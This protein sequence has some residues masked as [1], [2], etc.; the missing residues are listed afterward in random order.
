MAET[1]TAGRLLAL[2]SLLQGR[3]EWPGTLLARRLEVSPRTVRRDVERLRALGYPIDSTSGPA[4]GYSLTAGAAMPP[5]L[6]DDEEAIAVAIALRTAARSAVAGIEETALRAMVKLEQVLPGHL[7]RRVQALG[8]ATE[9]V[10][11]GGGPTVDGAVLT[12]LGTACRDQELLRFGYRGRDG[13]SS[14]RLVE[15]HALLARG[16]RWYLLAFD[17]SRAAWR[18]FRVDRVEA[19]SPA[20][21]GFRPRSIP[22]GDAAGYLTRT[23]A[24]VVYRYEARIRY[25]ASAAELRGRPAG[26]WGNLRDAADGCCICETSD[27]DLGWLAF[28][29]AAPGV[30]FELLEGSPELRERLREMGERLLAGASAPPP[31]AGSGS[32]RSTIAKAGRPRS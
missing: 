15:P 9:V 28:R 22:G 24:G 30:E 10:R 26:G 25:H 16:R 11:G 23:L 14:R 5:L 7:R 32:R 2:L 1:S 19:P 4:G 13:A 12:V 8:G 27:D 3:R 29:I 18:T 6:L 20:G 31:Q 21:R 17:P